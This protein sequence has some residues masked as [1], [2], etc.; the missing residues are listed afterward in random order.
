M[1]KEQIIRGLNLPTQQ[2]REFHEAFGHPVGKRISKLTPDRVAA[3]TE[4]LREEVEELH[5]ATN[6]K[7][8]L[9]ACLDIIYF[10]AGTLVEMGIK[11]PQKYFDIIQGCNMAKLG[12]DGK[13]IYRESDG[14]IV[15]P[16]GWVGPDKLL[17]EELTRDMT[18][19]YESI[20][21]SKE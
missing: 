5:E 21:A 12:P 18:K 15:K 6:V 2:V 10:A 19:D 11:D 14:K 1:E 9:D 7:D 13:P 16:E 20:K 8:Q 17:E 4:W 3:R